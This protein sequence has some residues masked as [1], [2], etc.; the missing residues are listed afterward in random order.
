MG[1]T[2]IA[3]AVALTLVGCKEARRSPLAEAAATC[4]HDPDVSCARPIFN[5]HDLRASQRY[6]RDALGFKV[7]WDY[8]EPPTFGSVSR[9]HGVIFL[10][11]GCQ[12]TPGVWAMMF[13]P[14]VDK[15]HEELRRR[16][17]KIRMPPTDMP[18]GLREMH[19]ADL[20]GN[21]LRFGCGSD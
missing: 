18:W 8:G 19:V 17:A 6:Y 5:V 21:V 13:V 4:A 3:V 1:R 20:D 2:S 11:Q 7:D 12:G 16:E 15:L 10:C 9:G 14:D